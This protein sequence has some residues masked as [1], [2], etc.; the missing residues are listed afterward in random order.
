MKEMQNGAN[1]FALRVDRRHLQRGREEPVLDAHIV[2]RELLDT[3]DAQ[4]LTEG[5]AM[6]KRSAVACCW[7]GQCSSLRRAAALTPRHDVLAAL[8]SALHVLQHC[9][10]EFMLN[11]NKGYESKNTQMYP[12]QETAYEGRKRQVAEA[13]CRRRQ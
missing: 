10:N 3:N 9:R 7:A 1:R 4:L 13:Q 8:L 6:Q 5:L 11:S 12:Q 2:A